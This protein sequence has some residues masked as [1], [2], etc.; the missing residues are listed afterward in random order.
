MAN[1]SL[2]HP[3]SC[4][5]LDDFREDIRQH[6]RYTL[7]KDAHS[8]TPLD[9]YRSV[10]LAVMDRLHDRWIETQQGYYNHDVKRVYYLSMEYLIGRLLDNM[11]ISL[12]LQDVAAEAME[13][14]GL[15]YYEVRT[16]EWVVGISNGGMV[17]LV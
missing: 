14:I 8:S 13:D 17:R 7:A 9:N 1:Q 16:G 12:G 6:L 10:V 2:K 11:L 3:R 5:N 4:M 15:D